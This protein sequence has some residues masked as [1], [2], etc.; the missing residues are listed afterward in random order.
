LKIS[1]IYTQNPLGDFVPHLRPREWS[2]QDIF[3]VLR[4]SGFRLNTDSQNMSENDSLSET[5]VYRHSA[6]SMISTD[7]LEDRYTEFMK[8]PIFL[9]STNL[10]TY[11][12]GELIPELTSVGYKILRSLCVDRG[13]RGSQG[14]Y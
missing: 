8:S 11:L 7:E 2:E 3:I 14:R 4:P 1:V 5:K 9:D 10:R 13:F 6:R 12:A